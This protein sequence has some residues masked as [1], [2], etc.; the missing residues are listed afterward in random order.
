MKWWEQI[1]IGFYRLTDFSI[2]FFLILHLSH[3]LL[4]SATH[5]IYGRNN[6][7]TNAVDQIHKQLNMFD[8]SQYEMVKF[9]FDFH[10]RLFISM[11]RN[12]L[13]QYFFLLPFVFAVEY[14]VEKIRLLFLFAFLPLFYL[15]N[16]NKM[17]I[18]RFAKKTVWWEGTS[19]DDSE[20]NLF[21][22]W[23]F[24]SIW[25]VLLKIPKVSMD[26]AKELKVFEYWYHLPTK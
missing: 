19:I 1:K 12:H 8:D 5:Q 14:A 4:E 18:Y 24:Q 3:Q 25:Q 11:I 9:P 7:N 22:V 10:F 23:K 17:Q 15:S 13:F 20:L 2:I 21:I 16:Q 6:T 26:L